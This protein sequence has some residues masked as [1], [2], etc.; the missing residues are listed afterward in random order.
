MDAEPTTE[1]RLLA[2]AIP[3]ED[4]VVIAAQPADQD[5]IWRRRLRNVARAGRIRIDR[6][7]VTKAAL[8]LEWALFE[9]AYFLAVE[10]PDVC[11]LVELEHLTG[12]MQTA[13]PYEADQIMRVRYH[14]ADVYRLAS[15]TAGVNAL[16]PFGSE[17][18]RLRALIAYVRADCKPDDVI[19]VITGRKSGHQAVDKIL[20]L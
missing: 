6:P 18:W 15:E 1:D 17:G 13:S 11:W 5:D 16:K 10:E 3:I 7:G 19:T 9:I 2:D 20:G 12:I 4:L 14:A 8:T